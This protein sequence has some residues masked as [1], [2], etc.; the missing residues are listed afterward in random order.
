MAPNRS[1]LDGLL[2]V[3][4]PA[5]MTSAGVVREVKRRLGGRKVGHLGTLDPFATGLLPL[6][7][8]EGA[9]IV[10]FLNQEHKAYRGTIALG[11][12]TDT[13]DLTGRTTETA[14]VPTL[15]APLLDEVA[16]RFCG[17]IQQA[18]PKFSALKR[19]G[20]PLYELARRGIEVDVE[21]RPVRIESL[22]LTATSG[23]TLEVSVC[24]SKG[25]YVRALARDI[26]RALG[27]VG[28]LASLR[29]IA[30]GPFS[31]EQAT[32]IEDV[33]LDAALP[34]LTPRQALIGVRELDADERLVAAVRQGQQ[35]GLAALACPAGPEEIAKLVATGGD[36]IAVLGASGRCWRILRVFAIPSPP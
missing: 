14:P 9:K 8:G 22:S 18:P 19:A 11:R 31:I 4:K 30:F 32:S 23:E 29:R 13:L 25:T 35:G 6:A 33:R 12:A 2:L 21:P 34:L 20:V 36:L 27:T 15:G 10:A 7:V 26:A 1:P 16:R 3:D 28:H 5:G 24:C 17:Q